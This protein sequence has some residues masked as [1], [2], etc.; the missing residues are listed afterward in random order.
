[1]VELLGKQGLALMGGEPVGAVA[2]DQHPQFSEEAI[3]RVVEL[4]QAGEMVGLSKANHYIGEAESSIA[5]WHDVPYCLGTSTGHASLHAALI[6][7]EVAQGDEV[8][9]SPY[10]WGATVSCILANN[11]TPVFVDVDPETGLLDPSAIEGAI[12][13]RTRAIVVVH[14]YGQPADMTSIMAVAKRHGLV[15]VEDGSQA[16]GAVHGGEKVGRFGDAAGFSCMGG[17]LLATSEAGYMLTRSEDVYWKAC[18][19]T[20]HMLGSPGS[21]G[22]ES[23]AGFPEQVKRYRDSLIYSYRLST[24][25]GVLL[26]EQLK[27]VDAEIS[28]RRANVEYLKEA[29]NGAKAVQFPDYGDGNLSAYHM[30]SVNVDSGYCG[31]SRDTYLAALQAEGVG[32]FTYV[33]SPIPS[34]ARLDPDSGAPRTMWREIVRQSGQNYKSLELPGCA[35]KIQHSIELSW[36]YIVPDQQR[37]EHLAAAFLKVEEHLPALQQ[38]EQARSNS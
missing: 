33:R 37:M 8:I 30:L 9:T 26:T 18:L 3:R 2:P 32:A 11:A 29:L 5:N 4:L 16:H 12:T 1:M 23:E 17:K 15:V 13:P 7:L 28:G 25:N 36:N 38:W 22:R 6:G 35:A 21:P 20:Q 24:I 27:S 10:S 14:I 34:W 19:G 31:V